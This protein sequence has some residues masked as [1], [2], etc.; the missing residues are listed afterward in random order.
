MADAHCATESVGEGET[1]WHGFIT[2]ISER[3]AMAAELEQY[4]DHLENLVEARTAA[5]EAAR[6]E[7]ER[8]AGVKSEFLANMSHEIRTPLHGMLGLAHIGKR[9]E[10]DDSKAR[11]IFDKIIHSGHLLWASSTTSSITRKWM[12]ACSGSSRPGSLPSCSANPWN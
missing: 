1:L 11:G 12:P 6:N 7:A 5:F 9:A 3:K 10:S 8:L 2:D 4:R